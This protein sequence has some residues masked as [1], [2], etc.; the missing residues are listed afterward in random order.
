M[1]LRNGNFCRGSF[2]TPPPIVHCADLTYSAK[3]E[4]HFRRGSC[5]F[6][7]LSLASANPK[8][9]ATLVKKAAEEIEAI[10]KSNNDPGLAE[11]LD[12]QLEWLSN[13]SLPDIELIAAY[14]FPMISPLV[15]PHWRS[16]V[17]WYIFRYNQL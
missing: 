15:P 14:Q 17:Q 2:F 12:L 7:F 13:E 16:K 5:S 4:G 9:T 6:A 8:D 3:G 10:K 11:Q 1:L